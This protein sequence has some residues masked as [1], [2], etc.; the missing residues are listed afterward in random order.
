MEITSRICTG[1]KIEKNLSEFYHKRT[2]NEIYKKCKICSNEERRRHRLERRKRLGLKYRK[3]EELPEGEVMT[4]K[5]CVTC[6]IEKEIVC[7]S[8]HKNY[9]DGRQ[10]EC[11]QCMSKRGCDIYLL[12][13]DKAEN[14]EK[15]PE[16]PT[17][18]SK[19]CSK[20][21]VDKSFN[22][23]N[24]EKR[25]KYGLYSVCKPCRTDVYVKQRIKRD[26]NFALKIL[27]R[28]RLQNALK[29]SN[30]KKLC[31]TLD[32]IGCSINELKEYIQSKFQ[33]GMTWEN[34]GIKTWNLDHLI[35]CSSFDLTKI[36][37]QRKC[38]HFTNLYPRWATT[39][40]ALEN[41]SDQIGNINKGKKIIGVDFFETLL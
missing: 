24:R 23:F 41:G 9:K 28:A 25:G 11:K 6:K 39:D 32:L 17:A 4:Y 2:G 12:K 14:P 30:A 26:P 1:C 40:I 22:F 10:T 31:K 29:A 7:F 27:L 33:P 38:F 34:R 19:I 16:L 5:T 20:C 18:T 21:K 13:K 37:E 36:E 35:P 15:Y 3:P 8:K